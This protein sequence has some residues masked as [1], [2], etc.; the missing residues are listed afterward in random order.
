MTDVIASTIDVGL[1]TLFADAQE[2][3][4]E[5]GEHY[6]VLWESLEHQT[7]GGK[8]IRPQLVDCA[9]RGL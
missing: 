9:Y 6:T 3:A 5:Y 4:G 2:R 7:A 1:R 8:R